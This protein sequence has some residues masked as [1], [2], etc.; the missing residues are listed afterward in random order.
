MTNTHKTPAGTTTTIALSVCPRC[1][2]IAKSGKMSCCGRGGSWFKNCGG[3]V[4]TKRHHTWYEGI[5]ACKTRSQSKAYIGNQLN[6][7]PQKDIHSSQGVHMANQK[8]VI[9]ATKEFEFTSINTST[10]M[11]GETTIVTSTYTAD[12]VSTTMSV[13][14][15]MTNSSTNIAMISLTHAPASTSITT[16]G[17][18]NLLKITVHINILFIMIF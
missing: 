11:S 1:G 2:T 3:T 5:Q 6:V 13:R 8:S 9:A 4:N 10:P 7:D 14:A 18:V 16:Q 12:H 15:L 17:C